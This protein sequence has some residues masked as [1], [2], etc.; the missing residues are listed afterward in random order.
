MHMAWVRS[1]GGRLESRYQYSPGIVYNPFPWP[2]LDDAA[3]TK[4]E[5]LAKTVLD[6]RGA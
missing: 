6:A 4:L 5:R 2:Q 3:K 1:I